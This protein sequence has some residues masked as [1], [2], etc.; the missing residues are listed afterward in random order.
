MKNHQFTTYRTVRNGLTPYSGPWTRQE[1]AHLLRRTT[2]GA[3]YAQVTETVASGLAATLDELLQDQPLPTPPLIVSDQDGGTIGETWVDKPYYVEAGMGGVNARNQSLTAW[4]SRLMTDEAFSIRE[5]MVLFWHNHFAIRSIQE[6]K[7]IYRNLDTLRQLALGNFRE[8]VKAITVDPAMLRFLNGNVNRVGSPNENYARELLEL[9]TIGKG[10][11]VGPGDYT[12]YTED[13]VR[14]ISRI[15]TGWVDYGYF[16]TRNGDFGSSFV[17]Q[18]HDTGRKTLSR[19]F[20]LA[21]I[22]NAGEEEYGNL[23]DVILEQDEVA[24]FIVRK[25]YRW[26]VYYE[27]TDEVEA[28]VIEP[29]A[30]IFRDNDYEIKPVLAAFLGSEHFFDV[31]SQ[32]PMIKNPLE[33]L[34]G[35]LR[36]LELPFRTN[37]PLRQVAVDNAVARAAGGLGM[38]HFNPPDVA[39]WKAYYQAPLYYRMWINSVTLRERGRIADV[40]VNIGADLGE[41]G[42]FRVE[43]LPLINQFPTPGNLTAMIDELAGHL[44]PRPITQAQKD[45]LKNL[46]VPGLPDSQWSI[47]YAEYQANPNDENIIA[48]LETKLRRTVAAMVA[49]PEFQLN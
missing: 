38:F 4:I 49:M 19:R 23:I 47:E 26:F 46:V 44:F 24:R 15:L 30:A 11:Q 13:D 16:N 14:E 6:P 29:L 12:H 28:T 32:G 35:M 45:Y 2:F 9:F 10:P 18:R 17:P 43:L 33:F 20:D 1:A 31:R 36:S 41:F 39:G 25:L 34:Y 7:Y 21:V 40:L 5:T 8:M 37:T 48:A 22:N 27:I 42:F 3:S